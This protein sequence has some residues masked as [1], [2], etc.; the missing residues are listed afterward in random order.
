MTAPYFAQSSFLDEPQHPLKYTDESMMLVTLRDFGRIAG[1][2][3]HAIVM[4]PFKSFPVSAP[5]LSSSIA[6]K[7]IGSL[8]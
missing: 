5:P 8:T 1:L 7:H 4:S 6:K 3:Y 2:G